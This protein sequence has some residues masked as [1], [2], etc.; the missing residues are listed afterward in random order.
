MEAWENYVSKYQ[1]PNT[2]ETFISVDQW[3]TINTE[4]LNQCDALDGLIDGI[5][6]D[7]RRCHFVPEALLCSVGTS[8]SSCLTPPQIMNL[9]TLYAGWTDV[10]ATLV[11]PGIPLGSELTGIQYYTN[12]ATPGGFGADFYAFAITND[13]NFDPTTITY[14][15]VQLADK[16]NTYGAIS[17]AFDP[18]IRAF[19][20][21][22][23]K[24]IHYHGEADS[25]NNAFISPLYY[26]KVLDFFAGLPANDTASNNK[27]SDFYRLFSI[28]GMGHCSGGPG[29]WAVGAPNQVLPSLNN[30]TEHNALQALVKWTEAPTESAAAA[31]PTV[32]IGTKYLNETTVG[33]VALDLT[34]KM[35]RPNC[36]WP[37]IPYY[38]SGDANNASSWVCPKPLF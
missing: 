18:D 31:A 26:G 15:D 19:K 2:L 24:I 4:V 20:S 12:S 34:V 1:Y 27:V 38:T 14:A 22:G 21:K 3:T 32:L 36:L 37:H 8:N 28:P 13:T 10:N 29:A 9:K 33:N 6:S 7:S 30:D 35:T 23:G 25:I 5:I 17:D 16:I 11:F